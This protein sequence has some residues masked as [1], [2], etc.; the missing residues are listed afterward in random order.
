MTA[1]NYDDVEEENSTS[2][3]NP[4]AQENQLMQDMLLNR[5]QDES[6]D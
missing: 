6:Q 4:Q 2:V 1:I 3:M 5:D